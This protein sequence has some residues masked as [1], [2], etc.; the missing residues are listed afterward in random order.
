MYETFP[1]QAPAEYWISFILVIQLKPNHSSHLGSSAAIKVNLKSV[2]AV[3]FYLLIFSLF[4][5]LYVHVLYN[6]Y[7]AFL[8]ILQTKM[9]QIIHFSAAI[10]YGKLVAPTPY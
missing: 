2:S 3:K 5:L 9:I 10:P 8:Y 4:L 1:F 7:I 6:S